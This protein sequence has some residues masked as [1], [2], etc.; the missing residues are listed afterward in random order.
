MSWE[1]KTMPSGTLSSERPAL[2]RTWRNF[3]PP[4]YAKH[5]RRF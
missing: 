3:S 5:L 1:V 4:P 2:G